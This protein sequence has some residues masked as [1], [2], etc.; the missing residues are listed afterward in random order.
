MA[1]YTLNVP[2]CVENDEKGFVTFPTSTAIL[3]TLK[4]DHKLNV[5]F[6]TFTMLIISDLSIDLPICFWFREMSSM[7]LKGL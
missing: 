2:E 7:Y 3:H 6:T 5:C 1:Y 4:N